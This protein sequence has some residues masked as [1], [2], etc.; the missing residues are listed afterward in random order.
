MNAKQAVP[1]S[2]NELKI[3]LVEL[4]KE[5]GYER[6]DE[7]FQLASGAWSHDYVDCRRALS[8]GDG[9]DLASRAVAAH[10]A[11]IGEFDLVGGLTMGAD[12]LAHGIAIVACKGW[13]SVRKEPKGHG[14][15]QLIE[16]AQI[17][18]GTK[19][20]LVEDVVTSGGS[21]LKSL[22]VVRQAGADVIAAVPL[23]DRGDVATKIFHDHGVTYSPLATYKDLGIE[24]VGS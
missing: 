5:R 1:R 20:L 21:M 4:L 6:R 17:L 19:V 23:L 13:F 11:T 10:A 14:T 22:E 16:G 18:P 2:A 12:P 7:A 24:P 3:Q 15:K 9:L 8:R